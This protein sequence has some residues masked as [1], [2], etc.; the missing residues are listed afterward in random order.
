MTIGSE[1]SWIK[2][3]S[4]MSIAISGKWIKQE[5]ICHKEYSESFLFIFFSK[6]FS[7]DVV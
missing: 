6:K 5:R 7:L 2:L 4:S 3:F 1:R